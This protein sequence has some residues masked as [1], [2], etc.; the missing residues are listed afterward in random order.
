MKPSLPEKE[1]KRDYVRDMFARIAARYDLMNRI[2][3]FGQDV[4]WRRMAI[5]AL[6]PRPGSLYLDVGAGTGDL[7]LELLKQSPASRVIAVDLTYQ[8]L[9]YGRIPPDLSGVF[10]VVADAQALPFADETFSGAVSGYLL[11]NVPE[12]NLAILEQ[13][14]V[15]A[16]KCRIVCL[17]TT[18]PDRNLL[19]PF[20][21]CYLKYIIPV[22]GRIIVRDQSAYDYLPESTRQ[23]VSAVKL[24]KIMEDCGMTAVTW[25]KYMFGTMAIHSAE[26]SADKS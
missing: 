4:Q 25:K 9:A 11:R 16:E 21:I 15:I 20:I 24:G 5:R 14:R 22:L 17:D 10:R 13:K 6:F 2:M 1:N 23:H 19:Y 18:P 8:M 26:K 3:S 12:I 7:T